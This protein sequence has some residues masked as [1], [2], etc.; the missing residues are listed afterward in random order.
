[1]KICEIWWVDGRGKTYKGTHSWCVH[2]ETIFMAYTII[3]YSV[4]WW[5]ASLARLPVYKDPGISL[6]FLCKH[7]TSKN[8]WP[9]DIIYFLCCTNNSI[10]LNW[11]QKKIGLSV[12]RKMTLWLNSE[13]LR[14]KLIFQITKW[15]L[16]T[17]FW[18]QIGMQ[19]RRLSKLSFLV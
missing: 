13:R 14:Y 9:S 2:K 16:A 7:N 12:Q 1:M 18:K 15:K 8:I 11:Q 17:A 5:Y 6:L 10:N 4:I 3:K 19:D